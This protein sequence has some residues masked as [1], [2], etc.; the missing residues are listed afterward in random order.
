VSC[1]DG[2]RFAPQPAGLAGIERRRIQVNGIV[3]GVGF[4]R[5]SSDWRR[6]SVSRAMFKTTVSAS[7][8][9]SKAL[10]LL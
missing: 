1:C 7:Q 2:R 5:L 4:G 3:Q 10:V 6:V 8:L 9:K